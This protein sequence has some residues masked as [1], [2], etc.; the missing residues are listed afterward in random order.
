MAIRVCETMEARVPEKAIPQFAPSPGFY[1]AGLGGNKRKGRGM[2]RGLRRARGMALGRGM[3]LGGGI[4][5]GFGRGGR[6][7]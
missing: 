1:Q 6:G 7:R 4:R 5:G 2:G 3:G